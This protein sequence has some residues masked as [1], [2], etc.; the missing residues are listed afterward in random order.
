MIR[1]PGGGQPRSVIVKLFCVPVFLVFT[2]CLAFGPAFA[3]TGPMVQSATGLTI[4]PSTAPYQNPVTL[5]ATVVPAQ[6]GQ[7]LFCDASAP[8]C[9]VNSNLAVGQINS[10]GVASVKLSAGRS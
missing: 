9:S 10:G 5:R 6:S 2:F 8:L 1:P 4:T 3:Q 7:V